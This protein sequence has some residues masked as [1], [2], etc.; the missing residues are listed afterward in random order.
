VTHEIIDARQAAKM[1]SCSYTQVLQMAQEKEFPHFRV[2]VRFRFRKADIE[3][4]MERQIEA[5]TQPRE[6]AAV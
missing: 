2:G 4:F 1:L 6:H 5:S 3:N